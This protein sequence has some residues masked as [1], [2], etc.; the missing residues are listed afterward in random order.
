MPKNLLAVLGMFF[1]RCRRILL[2]LLVIWDLIGGEKSLAKHN[3]I[4][5]YYA[6]VNTNIDEATRKKMRLM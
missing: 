2:K 3:S 4:K 1:Q 6:T 5:N